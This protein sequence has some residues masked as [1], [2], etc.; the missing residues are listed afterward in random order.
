MRNKKQKGDLSVQAIAGT[1]VVLLGIDLPEQKCLRLLGFALRREDHTD[2]KKY[3]MSGYK[4]FASIEPSPASG[5]LCSTRKPR[6]RVTQILQLFQ[7]HNASGENEK[8][9]QETK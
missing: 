5:V 2:G 4:S 1:H 6:P 3:W 8:P 7:K 9:K